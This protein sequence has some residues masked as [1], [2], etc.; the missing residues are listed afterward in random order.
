MPSNNL[1]PETP[2]SRGISS[3]LLTMKFMQRAAAS[4]SAQ[5]SPKSADSSAKRRKVDSPLTGEFHSFD[6]AA[7]QAAMK[8]QEAT[9][10]A[11]LSKHKAVLADTP[12]VLGG[13][14][15]RA[16]GG[17]AAGSAQKVAVVGFTNIDATEGKEDQLQ[18]VRAGRQRTGNFK[19]K[20]D[21]VGP[22]PLLDP[23][24]A[25]LQQKSTNIQPPRSEDDSNDS[26]ASDSSDDGS[27]M[28]TP[29]GTRDRRRSNPRL[30]AESSRARN[31]RDKRKK[32]E[33]NL[34]TLTSIS[35][36][37]SGAGGISNGG[38]FSKSPS[39]TCYN[40]GKLGHKSADC[41]SKS[42][43]SGGGQGRGGTKRKSSY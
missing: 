40:C 33:V 22:F 24:S 23:S 42:R 3:R 12:W 17:V 37:A 35:G 27:A 39:F 18:G 14:E 28:A 16:K 26:E 6:E 10:Q 25:D 1:A 21:Q 38:G 34:N 41:P 4:E 30:S 20:D 11:A 43:K 36:G 8:Q 2:P 29:D 31:F 13:F 5:S 9:R 15:S 32:S 19:S 7:I